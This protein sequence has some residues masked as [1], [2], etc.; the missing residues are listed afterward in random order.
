[1]LASLAVLLLAGQSAVA[2]SSSSNRGGRKLPKH[3]YAIEQTYGKFSARNVVQQDMQRRIAQGL[4]PPTTPDATVKVVN[5]AGSP[6]TFASPAAVPD[7]VGVSAAAADAGTDV[8]IFNGF[9]SYH[10]NMGV[11]ENNQNFYMLIDC[12]SANT[13]VDGNTYVQTATAVD[14]GNLVGMNYGIGQF[15][16]VEY[17]ETVSFDGEDGDRIVA[18]QQGLGISTSQQSFDGVGGILALGPALQTLYSQKDQQLNTIEEIIPTVVDTLAAQGEIPAAIVGL[19]LIPTT[20]STNPGTGTITFGGVS[21]DDF[22]GDIMYFPKESADFI[23]PYWGFST[24][25]VT[26]DFLSTDEE[27]YQSTQ[28][29]DGL[30]YGIVDSGATLV[31]IPETAY[32]TYVAN[33]PG[34]Y[35][36]PNTGLTLIPAA[37]VPRIGNMTFTIG[38]EDYIFTPSAQLIPSEISPLFGLPSPSESG[39][40]TSVFSNSGVSADTFTLGMYFLERFYVVLDTPNS[41][42]GFAYTEYTFEKTTEITRFRRTKRAHRNGEKRHEWSDGKNRLDQLLARSPFRNSAASVAVQAIA[43]S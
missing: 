25:S 18:T 28:L 24:S 38:G 1:M 9:S 31:A 15:R 41:R 6:S 22:T 36:D 42:I 40:Y 16:G 2:A 20:S 21:E 8:T 35:Q 29:L 4:A 30:K 12:G 10:I 32:A 7:A 3:T 23:A 37:Q 26:I 34:T 39:F 11:G 13:W 43:A 33:L 5:A 17:L 14:T 27:S 19:S